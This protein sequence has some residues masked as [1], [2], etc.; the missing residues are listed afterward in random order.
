MK[1]IFVIAAALLTFFATGC[2]T[3]ESAKIVYQQGVYYTE[4]SGEGNFQ[5]NEL[6][7]YM[8]SLIKSLNVKYEKQYISEIND[9]AALADFTAAVSELNQ[10]FKD[11]QEM[12]ASGKD[13]GEFGFSLTFKFI[14][15]KEATILKESEPFTF[16]YSA[17]TRITTAKSVNIN[18]EAAESVS[19]IVPIQISDL[20]ISTIITGY[21]L[22]N[23]DGTPSNADFI[24]KVEATSVEGFTAFNVSFS[25]KQGVD[26]GKYYLLVTFYDED[27]PDKSLF[28][29]RIDIEHKTK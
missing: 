18:T 1:K 14:V 19:G 8:S 20:K 25:A 13:F 4:Y 11:Y 21:K 16:E 6:Y 2:S 9:E 3:K 12:A 23:A 29:C 17:N 7:I 15:T 26:A 27:D 24:K 5:T 10:A 28:D 22:Y